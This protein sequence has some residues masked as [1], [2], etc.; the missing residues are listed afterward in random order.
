MNPGKTKIHTC[1][2]LKLELNFFSSVPALIL[3]APKY[4]QEMISCISYSNPD[5]LL[6]TMVSGSRS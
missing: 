1:P 4:S 3:L 6:L 5:Y 2:F